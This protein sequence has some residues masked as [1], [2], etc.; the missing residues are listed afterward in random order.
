MPWS[1]AAPPVDRE[2]GAMATVHGKPSRR[3]FHGRVV[4]GR[5]IVPVLASTI[6]VCIVGGSGSKVT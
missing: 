6:T 4:N 1:L 3:S 5:A 2:C